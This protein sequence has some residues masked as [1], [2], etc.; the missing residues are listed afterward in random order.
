LAGPWLFTVCRPGAASIWPMRVISVLLVGPAAP[1]ASRAVS[2]V[3]AARS[4]RRPSAPSD[5]A[6]GSIQF[7]VFK[8]FVARVLACEQL[9]PIAESA[10]T[11]PTPGLLST[12]ATSRSSLTSTRHRGR[13][14]AFGP[15]PRGW[16]L[17][18][19]TSGFKHR[20]G[21]DTVPRKTSSARRGPRAAHVQVIP[22]LALSAAA[23]VC[24]RPHQDRY[25]AKTALQHSAGLGGVAANQLAVVLSV[26][27]G[28]YLLRRVPAASSAATGQSQG[29][30]R[31]APQAARSLRFTARACGPGGGVDGVKEMAAFDQ[32]VTEMAGADAG[33]R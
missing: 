16:V 1:E 23:N 8:A 2:A 5:G 19:Q 26:A 15:V 10:S 13:R 29:G 25:F 3:T 22:G 28:Q 9:P 31:L 33:C 32:H 4:R 27:V 21:T 17:Q 18:P 14:A 12:W 20:G 6:T 24:E 11:A 30:Q 7:L